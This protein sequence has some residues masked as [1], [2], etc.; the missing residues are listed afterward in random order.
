MARGALA[1][2]TACLAL[3]PAAPALAHGMG[4][5]VMLH[6]GLPAAWLAAIGALVAA[7]AVWTLTARVPQDVQARTV[8]LAALPVVGPL[9]R[10]LNRSPCPLLGMRIVSVGVMLVVIA[11]GFFGNVSPERN[12]ATSFVWTIWWP[13]VVVSVLFVGSAWCA[14]CP[15][16]T[17]ATWLVRRRWWRRAEPHPGLN[18][19]VPPYLRHVW[20]A[21]LMFVVLT[22][23]E[24]GAGVTTIPFMT[25][26]LAVLM[27]V[28]SVGF[29]L[30]F[31]RKAFCRYACPV[32]R[33]LGLYSRLAPVAVRPLKQATCDRC[34]TMECYNGSK[35]IEPCPTNLT[36][37]RFNQNTFCLSC[38]NCA[39]SCPHQNV[40]WRLRTMGSE[41]REQAVP[42][43]DAAWFMLVLVGI[44]SFHG[45]TM[46]PRWNDWVMAIART[47]GEMGDLYVSFTLGMLG[48]RG[49]ARGLVRRNDRIAVPRRGA[50]RALR[51]TLCRFFVH[52]TTARLRLS[53][54]AQHGSPAARRHRRAAAVHQSVRHRAGGDERR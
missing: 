6:P 29:L 10:F 30:V 12:F 48:M 34:E 18:L 16:D 9:V 14:V 7:I 51:E 23:L 31:E 1:A 52:R 28:L 53:P 26:L 19:K 41:A 36:V 35:Q 44:T 27:I 42:Q 22:W 40:S 13:L 3:A 50:P 43:W 54:R 33:T 5:Q 4:E 8:N 24:F 20:I 32:G 17:L 37:G 39:L 25:A 11:A 46:I 21:L 2:G 38:G 47:T 15:W 45:L 49:P